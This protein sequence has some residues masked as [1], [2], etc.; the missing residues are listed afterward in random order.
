MREHNALKRATR[1][2]LLPMILCFVIYIASNAALSTFYNEDFPESLAVKVELM[3]I[4]FP[5][6]MITGA[7]ALVLLP[8]AYSV[9]SNSRWHRPLGRVA[10]ADV[11]ISGITAFPVALIAPVTIW[12]AAGFT[13]QAAS[14]LILLSL[15]IYNIRR[16]RVA[17]H[18]VC[19]LLMVATTSGAIF[20]RLFLGLWTRFGS[21]RYFEQFYAFDAWIAWMLPLGV[22][23]WIL[24]RSTDFSDK[25]R[26]V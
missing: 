13:A 14:W 20:F 26:K 2:I 6:H 8:I 10:A 18:R 11:L 15:G 3:P 22:S 12:S 4:I 7:L 23:A 21:F 16:H 1:F 5:I 9:R 25:I 19:M 17:A 24:L